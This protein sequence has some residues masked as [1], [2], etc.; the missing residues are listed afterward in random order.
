MLAWL[1]GVIV[2]AYGSGGLYGYLRRDLEWSPY[3]SP[4]EAQRDMLQLARTHATLCTVETIGRSTEHRPI[5]ALRLRGAQVSDI[6][7]RPRVLITAHIHAVEY[8][9]SYVAREIAHQLAER[10]GQAPEVTTL[11]D[12]ADVWIIPLLNPD[13]AARVWRRGGW[14]GLGASRFT[15]NGVDPNRNFPFVPVPGRKG[16]NSGSTKAG[17]AYYRGPQPLSEPECRALAR[18]CKRL[19]F[20]AAVNFHSFGGVI[21]LPQILGT[22]AAKARAAL[23]VFQ[24]TFQSYQPRLRYRPVPERSAKIVGQ[25]DPFLLNAFGTPSVTVEVSRPGVHLFKPWNSFNVF[26]WAN[27][28]RPEDWAANDAEATIR[29][30]SELVART[31]GT[32]SP[33]VYPELA[34]QVPD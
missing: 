33:A 25:L 5:L 7:R 27:P 26:W 9:G 14:S 29:T 22:D 31:G 10:Y 24:G 11:L 18:F 13:G 12:Q 30:L 28:A 4:D 15:A 17:S 19:Q 3:P 8:I 34:G 32:S 1:I 2:A 16:W 6:S 21:F 20:C 23:A